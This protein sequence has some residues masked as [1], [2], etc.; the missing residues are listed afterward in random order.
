MNKY[1]LLIKSYWE[2]AIVIVPLI[3]LFCLE[4]ILDI[5]IP[6]FYVLSFLGLTLVVCLIITNIRHKN[7]TKK[8][9]FDRYLK[10]GFIFPVMG[11][12]IFLIKTFILGPYSDRSLFWIFIACFIIAVI[13]IPLSIAIGYFIRFIMTV[14]SSSSLK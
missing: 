11:F 8:Q 14:R 2:Y 3:L 6:N 9:L 7:E 4:V 13:T 5:K 12:I 10:V 1:L